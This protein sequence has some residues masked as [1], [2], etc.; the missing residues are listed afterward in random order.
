MIAQV[1]QKSHWASKLVYLYKAGI[2][3]SH[4]AITFL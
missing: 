2:D 4:K 3:T 1:L